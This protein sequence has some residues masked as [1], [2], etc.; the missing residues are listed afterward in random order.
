MFNSIIHPFP[1]YRFT[2]EN[3]SEHP[4][5]EIRIEDQYW[6]MKDAAVVFET[7]RFKKWEVK[8][9]YHGNDG[10]VMPWND[11]AQLNLLKSK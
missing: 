5:V 10:T 3:L 7:K 9:F 11:T 1:N 8:Y 2:G 4:D 6:E